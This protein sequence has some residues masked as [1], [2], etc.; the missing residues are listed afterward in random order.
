M[1]PFDPADS[2][3]RTACLTTPLRRRD[4]L[5]LLAGGLALPALWRSAEAQ[6]AAEVEVA[7]VG[8]GAA[9]IAAARALAA[10]GRSCMLIEASRAL[11]GRARTETLGGT[12]LDLGV[13][14]L[15]SGGPLAAAAA[16]AGITPTA[17]AVARRLYVDGREAS[18][19]GYDGFLAALGRANRAIAATADAGRDIAV[20]ATLPEGG[21]WDG[22]VAALL[23][24]LGIG[25]PLDKV[26][27]VDLARRQTPADDS[28]APD[29]VGALLDR[30]GSGLTVRF[31]TR[32]A[33]ID[34]VRNGVVLGFEGGGTLKARSVI[35]AVPAAVIA[36]GAIRI[37][38]FPVRIMDALRAL[39]SGM[40]EHVGFLLR[41]NPLGLD[42][43]ERVVLKAGTTSPALLE[44]R[45]GAGDLHVLTFGDQQAVEIAARG[46]AAGLALAREALVAGF[47]ARAVSNLETVVVSRWSRHPLIRGAM[48]VALPGGSGSRRL[49]IDPVGRVILAGEYTS[50]DRWGTVDGAYA[51]GMA[52]AERAVRLLAGPA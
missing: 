35:L 4:A 9:G 34:A 42:P 24:P 31:S 33:R 26:S 16:S 39:P 36:A 51:S 7:V 37:T 30:L 43:D 29:G 5:G 22:T 11:G 6:G 12:P 20:A 18:N 3:S 19:G 27:T 2:A 44:A 17:L 13:A 25:R 47:G 1:N 10:A 23:G 41:E 32:V 50:I 8:G 48:A 21:P 38:P 40:L 14:R 52:A 15:D 28:R 46:D 45:I 49:F